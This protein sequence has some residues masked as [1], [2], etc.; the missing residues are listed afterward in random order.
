MLTLR[1]SS[2]RSGSLISRSPTLTLPDLVPQEKSKTRDGQTKG[3]VGGTAN[4]GPWESKYKQVAKELADIKANKAVYDSYGAEAQHRQ[5]EQ[6][7]I[8][9]Y[10]AMTHEQIIKRLN[11]KL[12]TSSREK[13]KIH[14]EYEEKLSAKNDE[15]TRL[16]IQNDALKGS[17]A[18]RLVEN[19][20]MAEAQEAR[21]RQ[22]IADLE[23]QLNNSISPTVHQ[24]V[25]DNFD[26]LSL[27]HGQTLQILEEDRVMMAASESERS[28]QDKAFRDEISNLH[29]QLE[30]ANL[31]VAE[32]DAISL[33]ALEKE[34]D[35]ALNEAQEKESDYA[36][37]V[38][39]L[40]KS[41]QGMTRSN[42]MI[43]AEIGA[44]TLTLTLTLIGCSRQR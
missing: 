1:K 31:K 37:R 44:L 40:E 5:E 21:L 27:E 18:A 34:K 22:R 42:E 32:H 35:R 12:E 7:Q 9:D 29:K 33:L 23:K 28:A 26:K 13:N 17:N 2:E 11:D 19:R 39:G 14:A 10:H 4:D 24:R 30:G 41:L 8:T 15:I 43:K 25:K 20:V 16:K 3:L 6:D 38:A 36:A